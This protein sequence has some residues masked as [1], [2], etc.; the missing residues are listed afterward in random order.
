LKTILKKI[1][2]DLDHRVLIPAQ[3]KSI[4][5]KEETNQIMF[6]SLGKKY[7]FPKEDCIILPLNSTSAENLATYVLAELLKKLE[8][9]K[10][11]HSIEVGV[12]EGYGQGAY[13]SKC[14]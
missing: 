9:I 10:H 14:F 4:Q 1:A 5:I 2:N 12:D 13:I 11:I 3:S 7:M 8:N 6:D